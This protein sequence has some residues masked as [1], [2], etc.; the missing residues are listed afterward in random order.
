MQLL[1]L[2]LPPSVVFPSFGTG[3][4]LIVALAASVGDVIGIV[5]DS[6]GDGDGDIDGDGDADVLYSSTAMYVCNYNA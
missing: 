1:A 6:N 3:G 2:S 4:V 5:G